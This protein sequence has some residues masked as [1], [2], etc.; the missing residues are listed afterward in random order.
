LSKESIVLQV[1][2]EILEDRQA[3]LTVAV[4]PDRVEREMQAAAR[5][6]AKKLN[7]PGFRKGK[8][9]YHI[10][11]R[12]VG[13]GAILEEALDPLGQAVYGEA[14][15]QAGIEPYASGALTDMTREPFTMTF[16]VP[17]QPEI[18]L[19]NYRDVR[20]TYE[21]TQVTDDDVEKTV[22]NIRE[23][24]ATLEPV[25]RPVELGDVA[26]LD[27]HGNV[28]AGRKK[29]EET[30]EEAAEEKAPLIDRHDVRVLITEESTYPVPGFPEK[31]VS[32]Q[33]GD[34]RSFEIKMPKDED[35]D[36]EVR[37]KTILFDVVCKEVYKRE[38][39]EMDDEF[40]KSVGE[41]ETL[42]ELRAKV[43]E[44]LVEMTHQ[45]VENEYLENVFGQLEPSATVNYP[46]VMLEERIDQLVED[47]DRR[48]RDR[49]LNVDEYL[50]L[51]DVT[52]EQLREDFREEARRSLKRALILTQ[53][54]ESENLSIAEEDIEDEIKTMLLSFGSQAA[55]A[56]QLFRSGDVRRTISNRLLSEKATRRLIDIAR[57]QAPELISEP[58]E[59]AFVDDGKP[60]KKTRARKPIA[61]AESTDAAKP[62]ARRKKS[63]A[64]AEESTESET[65]SSTERGETE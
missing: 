36:E 43:R 41:F 3:K 54:V 25:E 8:A 60:V 64:P 35:Y 56:Q 55:V 19:G 13:D 5:R 44:Q 49:G 53:L 34:E 23:E 2:T 15:D 57:G 58:A 1:Q 42:D 16:T 10:I 40:A 45:R 9:P 17:L 31:I 39:P 48:L 24:Q 20:V 52:Q 27:I 21:E 51:N 18:N 37:G 29:K 7:I 46:P 65:V 33:A 63:E 6:I 12:Y 22:S 50:R 14:L 4:S 59:A 47:F 11:A 62:K 32:M 28:K 61:E 38:L 26:V 30:S